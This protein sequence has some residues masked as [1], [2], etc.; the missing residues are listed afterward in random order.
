[1]SYVVSQLNDVIDKVQSGQYPAN[2]FYLQTIFFEQGDLNN[3]SFYNKVIEVADSANALVASG[4]AQW[5][6]FTQCY[7]QWETT[8]NKQAFQ[9]EC[10]NIVSGVNELAVDN[11]H[12]AVYPNPVSSKLTVVNLQF[13]E[14]DNLEIYDTM[15]R[16]VLSSTVKTQNNEF[17]IVVNALPSG[18]YFYRFNSKESKSVTGKFVKE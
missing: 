13:A 15:G 2:G 6:T 17:T 5:K 3:I 4:V 11:F 16:K 1:M 14:Y 8:Y 10:G 12:L 9:W 7:T 18:I